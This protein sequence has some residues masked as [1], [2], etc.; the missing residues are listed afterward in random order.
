MSLFEDPEL[1]SIIANN[2]ADPWEDT[3][4][5]GY[6]HL[7]PKQKGNYGEQFASKLLVKEGFDVQKRLLGDKSTAGYD[8]IVEGKKVE[9]KFSLAIRDSSNKNEVIKN[10]FVMNHVSKNKDWDILLFIGVNSLTD[11][12]ILWFTREDF[13]THLSGGN[14]PFNIQQGGEKI[15]NDDYMCTDI[16]K[17]LLLPFVHTG[18]QDFPRSK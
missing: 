14:G 6:V 13:D 3:P 8:R 5:K 17:L 16:P 1:T 11:L 15:K 18:I 7:S 10:K 12:C 4:L 2:I 9:I